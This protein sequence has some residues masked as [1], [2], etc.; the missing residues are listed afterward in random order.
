MFKDSSA[1]YYQIIN[2]YFRKKARQTL[3]KEEK[4]KSNNMVGNNTKIHLKMKNRSFLRIEKN[5]IK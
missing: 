1:E 2:K 5:I 4:E 3:F